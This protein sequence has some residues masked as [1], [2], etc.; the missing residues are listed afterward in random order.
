MIGGLY[1]TIYTLLIAELRNLERI[2]GII[3]C[4]YWKFN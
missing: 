4:L 3:L 2:P 1:V